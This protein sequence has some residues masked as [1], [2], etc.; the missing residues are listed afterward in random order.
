MARKQNNWNSPVL[1][2]GMQLLYKKSWQFFYKTICTLTMWLNNSI[3]PKEVVLNFKYL[4]G[5]TLSSLTALM[6][7]KLFQLNA[8]PFMGV[9]WVL[10][11]NWNLCL[12]ERCFWA[13]FALFLDLGF[14]AVAGPVLDHSWHSK[15]GCLRPGPARPSLA[16]GFKTSGP[17]DP[18][19]P[20]EPWRQVRLLFGVITQYL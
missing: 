16:L 5:E 17:S 15:S 13:W 12:T 6:S 8:T 9:C 2:V 18:S 10:I 11:N 14:P 20:N 3:F 1:L 4:G 19:T 7:L